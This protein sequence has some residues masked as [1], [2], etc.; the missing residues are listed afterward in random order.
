M[1]INFH[2]E[3]KA[4]KMYMLN[5]HVDQEYHMPKENVFYK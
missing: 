4:A 5:C 1:E 3:I 2:L